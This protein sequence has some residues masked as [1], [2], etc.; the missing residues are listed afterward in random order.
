[1]HLDINNCLTQCSNNGMCKFVN[2]SK[3]LCTCD[4]YFS[5][6]AC[7]SDTRPCSSS[8]CL[9]NGTCTND[10]NTS[11]PICTCSQFYTGS[12]CENPVDVCKDVT[13][14]GHGA[15]VDVNHVATCR[16]FYLYNGT[17]CEVQSFKQKVVQSVVSTSTVIAIGIIGAFYS[18]IVFMDLSKFWR[19]IKTG[20][21][22][23]P[24]SPKP[25][26]Y[27]LFYVG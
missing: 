15:C 3:L 2:G 13:C 6:A 1:M 18:T 24:Q 8:P 11:S 23:P 7:N 12:F 25:V 4:K 22:H 19:F 9:N 21:A 20:S 5:G 10:F 27:R 14:G 26:R 17:N 16:C